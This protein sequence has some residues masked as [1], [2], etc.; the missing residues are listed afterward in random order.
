MVHPVRVRPT[1][2]GPGDKLVR[3]I[4]LS[5]CR[6]LRQAGSATKR[7]STTVLRLD[8]EETLH[9]REPAGDNRQKQK[10]QPYNQVA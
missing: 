8:I 2:I 4:P 6:L 3:N 1:A 9:L 7:S 10:R 5:C